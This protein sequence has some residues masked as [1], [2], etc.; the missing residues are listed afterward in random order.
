MAEIETV[1]VHIICDSRNG[2]TSV[3]AQC[4]S[5]AEQS[6]AG[7]FFAK[8]STCIENLNSTAIAEPIAK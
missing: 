7:A 1:E 6:R 5:A 3:A 4:G 2:V 8:I